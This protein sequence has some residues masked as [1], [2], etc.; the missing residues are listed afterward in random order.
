METGP[1]APSGQHLNNERVA[2]RA[3]LLEDGGIGDNGWLA[4]HH[5]RLPPVWDEL[6]ASP[7]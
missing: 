7:T 5:R 6:G 4:D 2:F 1:P 3:A